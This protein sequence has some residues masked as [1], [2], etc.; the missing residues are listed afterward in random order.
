MYYI[1]DIKE[2]TKINNLRIMHEAD[3]FDFQNIIRLSCNI[4]QIEKFDP[5]E[6]PR[7]KK[8][9]AK[10]RYRDKIKMKKME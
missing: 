6:N 9:K 1:G 2:M 7:I 8:M 10:A 3:Y 5:N 4:P